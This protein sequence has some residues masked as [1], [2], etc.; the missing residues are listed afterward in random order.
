[1]L[2][3]PAE[4]LQVLRQLLD[5][6]LHVQRSLGLGER[7]IG[8]LGARPVRSRRKAGVVERAP[9]CLRCRKRCLV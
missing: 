1:M 8:P 4:P 2:K 3:Q 5:R 9:S 7:G 6:T